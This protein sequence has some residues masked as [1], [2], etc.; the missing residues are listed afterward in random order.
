MASEE[1]LPILKALGELKLGQGRMSIWE[2]ITGITDE[3]ILRQ[4][5]LHTYDASV[6]LQ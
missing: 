6:D 5:V 4:D 2:F 3:F 1:F